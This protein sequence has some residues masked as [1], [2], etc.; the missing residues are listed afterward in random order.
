[1]SD[2]WF[3]FWK[4]MFWVGIW[5]L[6]AAALTMLGLAAYLSVRHRT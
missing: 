4:V 1:M 3:M 5:L 6:I 2:R